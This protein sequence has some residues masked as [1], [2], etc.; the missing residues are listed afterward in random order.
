MLMARGHP[1]Q[2]RGVRF[3]WMHVKRVRG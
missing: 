1:Q 3:M 2:R